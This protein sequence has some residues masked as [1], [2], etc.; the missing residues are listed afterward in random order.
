MAA[1]NVSRVIADAMVRPATG[2]AEALLLSPASAALHVSQPRCLV[3]TRPQARPVHSVI[4]HEGSKFASH[5]PD[6]YN[7]FVTA[8]VAE[9]AALWDL[10]SQRQVDG[11]GPIPAGAARLAA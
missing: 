1:G 2:R 6:A 3:C 11:V 5:P 8:A 9:G 7:L 4:L 10:R